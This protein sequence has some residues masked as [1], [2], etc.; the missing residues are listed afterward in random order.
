MNQITPQFLT[1]ARQKAKSD[2]PKLGHMLIEQGDVSVRDMLTSLVQHKTLDVPLGQVLVS[3][4]S[5]DETRLYDALA[6]QW[7]HPRS[8]LGIFAPAA[9]TIGREFCLGH[10]VV[11]T[12]LRNGV[13]ELTAP[14]PQVFAK[15]E[16]DL[17]DLYGLITMAVA[18]PRE[19]QGVLAAHFA[20][21]LAG[22]AAM[23]LPE[24]LS[25]RR[26]SENGRRRIASALA[27]LGLLALAFVAYPAATLLILTC[28]AIGLALS[29]T[30]LKAVAMI[31]GLRPPR[32][33]DQ[34]DPDFPDHPVFSIMV[35]LHREKDIAPALVK[36][37]SRLSYPKSL[38]EV[39]LVV[40]E[41]DTET[42]HSLQSADLPS[43]M[44]VILVPEGQPK[45]KP[46]ALNHAI[47][48]C[49]GDVIGIYDAEDAPDSDQLER[50]V[51]KFRASPAHVACVQG[52]LQFYNPTDNWLARCFTMDYAAWFRVILP[53]ISRLGLPVPLGGTTLFLKRN[54]VDAMFGWDAHNVTEDADL[55]L[56]L[57]RAGYRTALITSVT[58]EE[59]NC[60]AWPWVKQRSR[61]I[62]GYMV[63]YW[64]HMRRP[65]A[66]YR[67]LGF[68]GFLGM[69][70]LF[71][72]TILHFIAAPLLWAFWLAFL[73][74]SHP[75]F[76]D[77]PDVVISAVGVAFITAELIG[78]AIFAT[79]LGKAGRS[80]LTPWAPTMMFY[81]L[82]MIPAGVKAAWEFV[83]A[84]VY[85]DKTEHGHSL[86]EDP[87]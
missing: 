43:W 52:I 58:G 28:T 8:K 18:S 51:A 85:W 65:V 63:T 13:L 25:C 11:P 87:A 10:G 1:Y 40:E 35:P 16:E 60:R 6:R 24:P 81:F 64:A 69:Q 14:S 53:G 2:R 75:Y 32:G 29:S 57:H 49:R 4:G 67:D 48:F 37:L 45:T 70:V 3:Q 34:P 84:P 39:V 30:I 9:D 62:K 7:D 54:A 26:M 72:S 86:P 41:N 47:R 61:W 50:V 23:R 79:A 17:Q 71:L 31:A 20:H 66:L 38:L 83:T 42:A 74:V 36:R 21:D 68:A 76:T 22:D 44:R 80:F 59:A 12:G 77:M 19:I 33:T 73:G 56:R 55:G 46:R 78:L 5:L 82:L 27:V 15:A